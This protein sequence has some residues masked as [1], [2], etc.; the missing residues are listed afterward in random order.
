MNPWMQA[1]GWTLIHFVWQGGLLAL[2]TAVGLRLCRRRS[3]DARSAIACAGLTA[4]LAAPVVTAAFFRTLDS[5]ARVPGER[6]PAVP[7]SEAVATVPRS[8]TD[9]VSSPTNAGATGTIRLDAVLPVVVWGWLAGVTALLARFA[10]GC[11]RVR[12]LRVAALAETVS[13]WQSASERLAVR[14]RLDV[15]LRVVD[16]GSSMPRASSDGFVR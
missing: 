3:S 11:W 5:A 4:M 1:T 12:R 13:Q 7:G 6:S 8:P 10:G 9:E 2:A 14:L 15:P 16:R